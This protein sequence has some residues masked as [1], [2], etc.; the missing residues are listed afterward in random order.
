MVIY[1]LAKPDMYLIVEREV[2]LSGDDESVIVTTT[3]ATPHLEF[4][5]LKYHLRHIN[6]IW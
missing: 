2:I 4:G 6:I 1:I 3:L 5:W